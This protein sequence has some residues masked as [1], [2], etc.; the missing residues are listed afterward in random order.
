MSAAGGGDFLQVICGFN[1]P[2]HNLF[3]RKAAEA[4]ERAA[5]NRKENR[6]T[7]SDVL[8]HDRTELLSFR[9]NTLEIR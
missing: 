4:E 6:R 2:I 9:L 8:M 7:D 5:G 3:P 1:S